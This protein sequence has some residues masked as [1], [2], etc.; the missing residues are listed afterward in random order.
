MVADLWSLSFFSDAV[1]F[2]VPRKPVLWSLFYFILFFL[3]GD[4]VLKSVD[5]VDVTGFN[6]GKDDIANIGTVFI[7]KEEPVF[8]I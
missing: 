1:V 6:H 5:A 3:N 2:V 4:K 8:P 7:L